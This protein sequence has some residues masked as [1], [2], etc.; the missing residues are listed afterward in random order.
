MTGY[1]STITLENTRHTVLKITSFIQNGILAVF[2]NCISQTRSQ[3]LAERATP[4]WRCFLHP[5]TKFSIF[6]LS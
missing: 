4:F 3:M 2:D 6:L 1:D 5:L